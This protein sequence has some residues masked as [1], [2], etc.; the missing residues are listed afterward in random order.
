MCTVSRPLAFNS[1]FYGKKDVLTLDEVVQYTGYTK[2]Y[3]YKLCHLRKIPHC[4]NLQGRRLFFILEEIK[5]W[6]TAHRN[7]TVNEIINS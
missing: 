4:N 5:E 6:C 7:K 1:R 2:A 3:I